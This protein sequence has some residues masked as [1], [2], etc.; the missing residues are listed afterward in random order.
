M[1]LREL[2]LHFK[3]PMLMALQLQQTGDLAMMLLFQHLVHVAPQKS[4]L[5]A[6]IQ[7]NIA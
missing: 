5:K 4:E 7:I 2:F 6:K 1:K 3:K